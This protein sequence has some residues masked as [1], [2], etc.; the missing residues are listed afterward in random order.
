MQVVGGMVANLLDLHVCTCTCTSRVGWLAS[1][2]FINPRRACAARVTVLGL[3]FRLS[4]CYH[5]THNK[6][7][8]MRYQRVQCH[9]GF[10]FKMAFLVKMLSSKVMA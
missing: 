3:S 7:A 5:A 2:N 6:T 4:V 1:C 10:I 9:T 8:K